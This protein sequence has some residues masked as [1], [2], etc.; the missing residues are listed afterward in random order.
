MDLFSQKERELLD[1][2]LGG[3]GQDPRVSGFSIESLEER[4]RS[5]KAPGIQ[6]S[7]FD[8]P[9]VEDLNEV[10][11]I[12]GG[13]AVEEVKG[14]PKYLQSG[15]T[16]SSQPAKITV[17]D[18]STPKACIRQKTSSQAPVSNLEVKF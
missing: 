10:L 13:N 7:R 5:S 6:V 2:N 16:M 4:E 17:L 14:D 11:K 12:D 3:G 9:T 15:K 18:Q 1:E 8:S